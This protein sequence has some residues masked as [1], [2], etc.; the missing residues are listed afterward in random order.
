MKIY[1][2]PEQPP[3][4]ALWAVADFTVTGL[5]PSWYARNEAAYG[6]GLSPGAIREEDDGSYSMMAGEGSWHPYVPQ[7]IEGELHAYYRYGPGWWA[8]GHMD[9]HSFA[10]GYYEDLSRHDPVAWPPRLKI[11]MDLPRFP[12]DHPL[13][14]VSYDRELY[15]RVTAAYREMI[16]EEPAPEPPVPPDPEP[17]EPEPG[18]LPAPPPPVPAKV[19]ET[20]RICV[21]WLPVKRLKQRQR[22]GWVCDWLIAGCNNAPTEYM[23]ETVRAASSWLPVVQVARRGRLDRLRDYVYEVAEWYRLPG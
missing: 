19:F 23:L 13:D 22:L 2:Y 18:P 9:A 8:V 1:L 7:R 20:A 16:G 14:D 4:F 11:G 21:E 5:Q 17:P 6:H 3:G 10:Q 15:M 12:G